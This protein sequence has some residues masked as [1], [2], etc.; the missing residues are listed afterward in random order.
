MVDNNKFK[1]L[2][3]G[4]SSLIP[5]KLDLNISNFQS[6]YFVEIP[7][8]K[9]VENNNQPRKNFNE[10]DILELAESIK[11]YGVL[12]PILVK[13]LEN[14]RYQIIAGERRWRASKLAN[15]K[16]VPAI[17][18]NTIDR[19]NVEI[20]LIENIQREDLNP[21][22]EANIYKTLIDEQG[23]TQEILAEKIG[24]SRSYV[25]NLV[26]LLKLPD[27]FKKLI[28]EDKLSAGHARLLLNNENPDE[29]VKIIQKNNLSVRQTEDIIKNN[30]KINYNKFSKDGDVLN[31]ERK[32]SKALNLK[33]KINL[34]KKENSIVIKFNNM[35]EFDY[36]IAML[37]KNNELTI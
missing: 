22:E 10:E 18:K 32:I 28:F 25:A 31:L 21:L 9:I 24:K 2:G 37:C 36:L 30:N 20:S 17:I 7:I 5:N 3:K 34:G 19:Q 16:F 14:D 11:L 29:L 12:Q 35:D 27:K 4:L 23:Y 8:D 6:D 15:L 33:T 1:A 13:S 26:R